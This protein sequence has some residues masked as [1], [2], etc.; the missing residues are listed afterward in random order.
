M[1]TVEASVTSLCML[2]SEGVSARWVESRKI[3]NKFADGLLGDFMI[4]QGFFFFK[5][6]NLCLPT[7]SGPRILKCQCALA[8]GLIFRPYTTA[9]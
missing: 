3:K 4:C 6:K 7:K 8:T 5:K 9:S 2:E 1:L